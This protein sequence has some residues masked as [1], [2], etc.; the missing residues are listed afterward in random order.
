L[1]LRSSTTPFWFVTST[2]PTYLNTYKHKELRLSCKYDIK[3]RGKRERYHLEK[4]KE[5]YNFQISNNSKRQTGTN[6]SNISQPLHVY[7][8]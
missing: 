7:F 3:N 4:F 1:Y 6:Q 5:Q 2:T 8:R